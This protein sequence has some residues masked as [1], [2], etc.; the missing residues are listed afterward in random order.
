MWFHAGYDGITV[1]EYKVFAQDSVLW[2][3]KGCR[4]S[5]KKSLEKVDLLE[6]RNIEL[7]DKLLELEER[8]LNI[9]RDMVN[10]V[11]DAVMEKMREDVERERR[12]KN[13]VIFNVGESVK[14]SSM[15]RGGYGF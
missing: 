12:K 5:I 1:P 9:K 6:Q 15:E 10:E 4:P 14:E 11:R 8:V 3:C 2:F 13:L 7:E